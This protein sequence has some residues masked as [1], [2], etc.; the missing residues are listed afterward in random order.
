MPD[1]EK[2]TEVLNLSTDELAV[3]S[4]EEQER[5]SRELETLQA[6]LETLNLFNDHSS[7][8]GSPPVFSMFYGSHADNQTLPSHFTE[9][10]D[11]NPTLVPQKGFSCGYTRLLRIGES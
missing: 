7:S 11:S 3:S 10:E 9:W 8:L 6:S 1:I 2:A 5:L 4:T